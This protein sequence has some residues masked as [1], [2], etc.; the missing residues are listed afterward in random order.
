MAEEHPNFLQKLRTL[1]R[2]TVGQMIWWGSGLVLAI[3]AAVLLRG[4]ISCYRLTSLPGISLPSCESASVPV[5]VNPQGTPVAVTSTPTISAPAVELP[6]PWDGAS[7]VNVLV[8]G[9]DS[10]DVPDYQQGVIP[11]PP[12]TDTMILL[13]ID[14][15]TK[16]AG[17]ISIPRDLWINI[18]GFDYAKI[19]T[20]YT[21]GEL[22][23]LPGGGPGLAMKTVS[24]FLGVPIQYYAWI[25]FSAFIN[26]IDRMGGVTVCVPDPI[27]VGLYDRNGVAKLDA[28]CQNMSGIIALGYARNRYTA[29]GDVDRSNR[30]MQVI[31]ALRDKIMAPSSWGTL[32]SEA[33]GIYQDVSSGVHTNLTLTDALKLAALAREI[34]KD[35][36]KMR[37]I[38][39]TMMTD[40]KAPDG[41]D[42][43]RP[44]NDKVR[45]L[46]DDVF[47]VTTLGPA[48][49]SNPSALTQSDTALQ[50]SQPLMQAEAARVVVVN[51]T[52]TVGLASRTSDYLKSQGMNVTAFGNTTDY[53]DIYRSP[54][55]NR[56]VIV[57]HSGKP[58]AMYY[59]QA[60]FKFATTSQIVINIDPTAPEDI[61]VELGY[62]WVVPQ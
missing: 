35:N 51:G 41:T 1:R 34:P 58:Y 55:P 60:L 42:I 62:D 36:I 30:Q 6:A 49:T 50:A 53:P 5:V 40:T 14:P 15:L 46:R 26:A 10:R 23:H 57:V 56:T 11:G 4:F 61:L 19:N 3:L 9:L 43:L 17:A 27:T 52:G 47:G 25:E 20:A 24:A 8:M 45:V 37:V 21:L 48:A 22:Y 44:F 13:T 33:P 7:R 2:P 39:Y 54:F 18:P 28:G 31:L 16:T 29:N 59:L 32:A 38:D 12:R